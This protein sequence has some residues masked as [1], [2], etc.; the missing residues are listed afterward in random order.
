MDAASK[1][2][3]ACCAGICLWRHKQAPPTPVL[4]QLVAAP[5]RSGLLLGSL[6]FKA[7]DGQYVWFSLEVRAS[8]A[9]EVGAIDVEA[10]RAGLP[11]ALLTWLAPHQH[12][13]HRLNLECSSETRQCPSEGLGC[14]GSSVH[15]SVGKF[16]TKVAWAHSCQQGR[17]P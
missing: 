4:L 7:P 9:P 16:G 17:A 10:E 2:K 5:V 13:G 11:C 15:C 6:N 1:C 14:N 8:E 12:M 3:A